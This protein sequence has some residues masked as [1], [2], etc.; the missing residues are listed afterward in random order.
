MSKITANDKKIFRAE[1][2]KRSPGQAHIIMCQP[3]VELNQHMAITTN[4]P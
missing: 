2:R 1:N 3:T 4:Q